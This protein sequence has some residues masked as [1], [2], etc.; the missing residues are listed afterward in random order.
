M[1][2]A[3]AL[4]SAVAGGKYLYKNRVSLMNKAKVVRIKLQRALA[5]ANIDGAVAADIKQKKSEV[6]RYLDKN[7]V[8]KCGIEV[9]RITDASTYTLTSTISSLSGAVTGVA[10]GV[11]ETQR[12]GSSYELKSYTS[13]MIWNAAATAVT[14]T[15]VRLFLIKVGKTSGALP[16]VGTIL[17]SNTNILSPMSS[18]TDNKIQE[19]FTVVKE[20]NFVLAPYGQ[21]GASRKIMINYRPKG[22]HEVKYIGT[23]TTG[24]LANQIEGALAVYGMFNGTTAPTN[25]VNYNMLE[26][27]D[28]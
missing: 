23:D 3:S 9:K 19:Q 8:R 10:Q 27:V 15:Y 22:C 21:S 17:D 12:V 14:P 2:Y 28:V 25:T 1:S 6:R 5:G 4:S 24:G 26:W 11:G 7:Y 20:I 18:L 16:G 13:K